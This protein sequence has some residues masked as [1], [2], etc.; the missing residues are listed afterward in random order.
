MLLSILVIDLAVFCTQCISFLPGGSK[1]G[2]TP[3][4]VGTDLTC[5]QDFSI[6]HFGLG[7]EGIRPGIIRPRLDNFSLYH[8]LHHIAAH[9]S[10]GLLYY[11]GLLSRLTLLLAEETSYPIAHQ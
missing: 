4:A 1:N 6:F 7:R 5:S 3:K 11:C 2:A 10:N 9:Y 8:H